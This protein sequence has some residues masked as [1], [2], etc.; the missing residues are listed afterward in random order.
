MESAD[1]ILRQVLFGGSLRDK[2]AGKE[3]SYSALQFEGL[4]GIE[5]IE[6]PG[7]DGFLSPQANG[8][9]KSTFPRHSEILK[10]ETARGRLLHFFANH[11]LLAIETMAYVLLRFPDAPESFKR[12]VFRVL[13]EE[14]GH[15]S[16]YL[17]RMNEY[18]VS[19]G[20]VPLNLYFWNSLKGMRTPLDFVVQMSLTFEQAN[21]D[22]AL[23]Y[24]TL[25]ETKCE[26]PKT[27][28]LLRRVHED[29]VRH[30]Q[31]GWKWFQEWRPKNEASDFRVYQELLPFPMTP[32]RARG[33]THFAAK[34]RECAGLSADYIREVKISGGS[35]GRVPDFYFFNPECEIEIGKS[36]LPSVLM[37]R[38][39]DLEALLLWLPKEDDVV[40]L[41]HRPSL[42]FLE[43]VHEIRGE[44]PEIVTSRVELDRYAAFQEFKP[45][46]FGPSA[47]R[48]WNL[49]KTKFRCSPEFPESLHEE[50]LFSKAFWKRELKTE[51][52]VFTNPDELLAWACTLNQE[53]EF[54]L[55]SPFGTSGRGHLRILASQLNDPV[56]IEKLKKR[57]KVDGA[58]VVEPFYQKVCDFSVQ[59]EI[60]LDGS[61]IKDEP[62]VFRVD[63]TLQYLGS[64]LGRPGLS[65]DLDQVSRAHAPILE[66]LH[67]HRYQ[68]PL[69]VDGLIARDASGGLRLVPVIEVNARMTMGRVANAIEAALRKRGGF[70]HGIFVFLKESDLIQ[71][72]VRGFPEFQE[73]MSVR[74]GRDFVPAT[75]VGSAKTCFV[76]CLMNQESYSAFGF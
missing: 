3:L 26:D 70:R 24:A 50:K 29:E 75:D 20:E 68:G 52:A 41:K 35:R 16:E 57:V 17:E 51:G 39:S 6:A 46:G 23:E 55:K 33:A 62:R 73:K 59:Y 14:Q 74:Y 40:E 34:S 69:G 54:L 53:S 8:K 64:Y 5:P 27:A 66:V 63:S 56:L 67:K 58:L 18:G 10:S 49:I 32:R 19:F 60:R 28:K 13:Q 31:H 7:R 30:V 45:W 1:L 76:F 36:T 42:S 44:L 15:F 38:V 43:N 12:G 65:L 2:L 47:W 4:R 9:I 22:F 11:E 61:V 71:H 21:L 48:K 37:D 25:F 72:G